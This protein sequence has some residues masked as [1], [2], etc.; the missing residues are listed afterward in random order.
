MLQA[1]IPADDA[2]RVRALQAL[3]LLD[4]PAEERFDRLTRITQQALRVPIALVSLVDTEREW[5]KSRLGLRVTESPR[6]IA[7]SAHSILGNEVLVVPDTRAD[8]RFA[9]NPWVQGDPHIRFYVGTPL[10][11]RNGLCVG[12]LCAMDHQARPTGDIPLKLL[13]DLAQCV[14]EELERGSDATPLGAQAM[15]QARYAV[16]VAASDDAIMSKTLDGVITM[17]GQGMVLSCNPAAERLF[18]Y[19]QAQMLQ[20]N[21][22]QLMPEPY[23]G[24]RDAYLAIY[25]QTHPARTIGIGREVT[26]KRQDGSTFPMEL[27]VSEMPQ[28]GGSLFVGIVRDITQRKAAEAELKGI[29]LRLALALESAQMGI[30]DWDIENNVLLWDERM[31]VL[32]GVEA[33]E[34][35][36][37]YSAWL[38]G[39]H[40]LDQGRCDNAIQAAL[41]GEKPYDIEFRVRWPDGT[42]RWIKANGL[43]LRN[44]GGQPVR[45]VGI[46]FDITERKKLDSMKN[47]FISTVSHE[48]RTPLTSIRGALGL[49]V[50]K[51]ASALPDK[52]RQLLDT[53]NRN[54]ER[55]TLLINDI[56]DLEK[57]ESGQLGFDLRALDLAALARQALVANEGYGQQH[58]VSLRLVQAPVCAMVQADELRLL[59]VFANLISNAVKYSPQGATV[60]LVLAPGQ[61]PD[62]VRVRV[63]DHGPGIPAEFRSRMFQR[64]AQADSS[65]TRRRGGTGLGLSITKAIVERHG[66]SIGFS[67]VE[68]MGTEFYFELPLWQELAEEPPP[69]P[70]VPTIL[71]CE[72]N[73]D[74]AMALAEL[75]VHEGVACDRA[76]N[77]ATALQ[78]LRRKPYRA[79]LLELELPDMDGRTV[80]QQLRCEE[81]TQSLP[82]VVVSG[83]A[84]EGSALL[85][86]GQILAVTDWLQKPV[87]RDRLGRAL[88]L[89]L[90]GQRR[91]S[92]LHV[93]DDTDVIQITRALLEDDAD[94]RYAT[95]LAQA[96]Q[97]L[98]QAPCDL[99]LLDLNLPDGSGLNLLDAIGTH[100]RVIVFS[101]QSPDTA[102]HEYVNAALTKGNASNER[103]LAT[104]KQVLS[105]PRP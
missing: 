57:I 37:A 95:S 64:F 12:S 44:A 79:L 69:A 71:I 49:V 92:V 30:W 6:A 104:I 89:V 20:R 24:A 70:E 33:H 22:S 97:A 45:M 102:F 73:D 29:S 50:G 9:D 31:Y 88:Q 82:V 8:P 15:T 5:F 75:L 13:M 96:R 39:V 103:L 58:G 41:Q 94:Y 2:E 98:S 76:A 84:Q 14:S 16:I 53:A 32:Y 34:F 10:R 101:G 25:P 35:E 26:G 68:H 54:S 60:D 42:V 11:L 55:L 27:A 65:D 28:A 38:A 100:S 3:R 66:G 1:P 93:E 91:P 7:F 23:A 48:L 17:D 19:S 62:T 61:R 47:E 43:V 72:D 67:T 77:G 90:R 80:V 78:M 81:A 99:L 85:W 52:A 74:A 18:G 83:R 56:L 4:T 46:N 21:V 36:G 86:K 40:P 51:H 105:Q 59:Q 63:Q 87:D